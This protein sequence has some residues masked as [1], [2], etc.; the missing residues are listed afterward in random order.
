LRER[1]QRII[2]DLQEHIRFFSEVGVD[3]ISESP[4][5]GD[6]PQSRNALQDLLKKIL[7]CEKCPLARSRT[8]A[9]PGEGSAT[10]DLMFVGEGPG[11]DEDIQGR[12]FVGDAGQ[13]LTKIIQAMGLSR[14]DVYITNIVKCR[15]PGNRNPHLDE[16][17]SCT[18]Y[19]RQQLELIKPRI[20]VSLGNV[21]TK[22]LLETSSGISALRGQFHTYGDIQIMP[23]FHPSFLVRNE[24][25]RELRRNVWEDMKKV[26]A[27]LGGK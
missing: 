27:A 12:P 22:H 23:T 4:T 10:A 3:F 21:P 6:T 13:L 18:P 15:P 19:L 7:V 26:M 16:I 11:R 17:S 8:L 14:E 24:H 9:V 1:K 2:H 5:P 25:N 20:I